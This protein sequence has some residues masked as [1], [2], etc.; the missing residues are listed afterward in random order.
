MDILNVPVTNSRVRQLTRHVGGLPIKHYYYLFALSGLLGA[1]PVLAQLAESEMP[2]NVDSFISDSHLDM[3]L[4]NQWKYLKENAS[5][6]K[7]VHNA[8]GQSATLNFESGYLWDVIG[9]DASYSQV[10][11]LAASDYFSTRALLYNDGQGMDKKNAKGFNKFGQRYLKVKAGDESAGLKAK[12][13]WRELKNFGVLTTSNRLT[14]N[15][16]LGY[17]GSLVYDRLQLDFGWLSDS[18]NRDS[19]NKSHFQ[20][21]DRRNIANVRTGGLSWK[22]DKMRL[23]Y[24]YGEAKDYQRRHAVEMAWQPLENWTLASQVYGSEALAGY[25][26]MA[27]G[28]KEYDN[29]AWHYVGEIRWQDP[30]WLFKFAAAH[31]NAHKESGVGIY[32]RHIAKNSRGRFNALTSAGVDYMRDGETALAL[33]GQYQTHRT[34]TSGLQLNYGQFSYKDNLVRSGEVSLINVWAP[35]SAPLKDLSVFINVG[36]GWH[37]KNVNATPTLSD[38]GNYM[39]SPSLSSEIVVDYRFGLF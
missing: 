31:T 34:L 28:K 23:S 12:I 20:T 16:Y 14:K 22:N 6:P 9:F 21:A 29:Q 10:I 11:K 33:Y 25:K 27:A 18:I 15:S 36:Y 35:D 8:W 2:K 37:Y 7:E 3:A 19:P 5:Q 32:G 4:R 38:S 17:S 26:K 30:R 1:T 13:G 24:G 39:R